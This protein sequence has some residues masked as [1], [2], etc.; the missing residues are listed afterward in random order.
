VRVLADPNIPVTATWKH[1]ASA[2]PPLDLETAQAIEKVRSSDG[3]HHSKYVGR[4]DRRI[5]CATQVFPP[6]S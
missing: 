2:P 5:F 6:M 1:V 4:C 3:A